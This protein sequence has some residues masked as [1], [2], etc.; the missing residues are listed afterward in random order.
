MQP[1]MTTCQRV[2]AVNIRPGVSILSILRHLNYKAWFALAEFV[3]NA[4]QSYNLSKTELD[5]LEGPDFKLMVRI[6]ID[7]TSPSRISVRDNAAGISYAEFPRAFRP[8]AVPEDKSGLSEFGMGMKSAACWF[9]PKWTVRTTAIGEPIER[10]VRFDVDQ[11]VHDEIEEL[12]I[13]EVGIAADTHFTEVV[14]EDLH[15]V[16]RN[17]TVRKIKDHLVDIYRVFQRDGLLELYYNDE[18]LRYEEPRILY[19]PLATEPGSEARQWS[20]DI[21]FDFGE[22]LSVNGF[23]A[24]MDPGHYPKSGFALFR[25][26]RLIQGSAD[27]GYRPPAIFG[28]TRG[29]YRA[30]RLFGELH[31]EG[32]EVS[33]TKDGFRWDEN[34]EPFLELL[35]EHLNGAELPL[36]RQA[37]TYRARASRD[38][39]KEAAEEAIDN[40]VAVMRRSLV[41]VLRQIADKPPAETQEDPLPDAPELVSRELSI[42]FR[43]QDWTVKVELT[44]DPAE[45]QWLAV[46]NQASADGRPELIEIRL[47]MAHPFMV[48]FAQTDSEEIEALLRVAAGLAL[49]EKLARRAGHSYTGTIRRNLNDILREAL[50]EP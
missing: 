32:F 36:L 13:E 46:S 7:S 38:E 39:R 4:I 22:G 49:S 9:A 41:E 47:S 34:E 31:L 25:R 26:G 6:N 43:D 44:D 27:E 16:P 40:T 14:L 1:N 42:R 3:D 35:R 8:A 20:K 33:H 10:T 21:D 45:G 30:L 29:S 37:D 2:D 24:L 18:T 12:Q 19:A 23:A 48:R 5:A 17:N 50:S 11:I 28:T 15:H